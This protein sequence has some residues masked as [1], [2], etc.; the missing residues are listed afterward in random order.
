[1]WASPGKVVATTLGIVVSICANVP[2]TGAE[3]D[4]IGPPSPLSGPGV[5]S[6]KKS[7][8]KK[9]QRGWQEL[10][11]GDLTA[12]KKRA[13]RVARTV[14]GRLLQLQIDLAEGNT[15]VAEELRSFCSDQ[16]DYAAAWATLSLAAERSGAEHLALEAAR[17][18]EAQWPDS[19][20]SGRVTEL[21]QRWV[22]DRIAEATHLFEAGRSEEALVELEA[23]EALAPGH[24]DAVLLEAKIR[25]A[26]DDIRGAEDLLQGLP[27]DP[28]AA[29]LMGKIAESRSD[30][31]S[32]MDSF[33]ALPDDY[34]GREAALERAQVLWRLN[35]LPA[36]ARDSMAADPVT[37]GDL[38]VILISI[39]PRL[40]T[41]PGGEV[42]VMSDIVDHPGQREI[43]T[44]ARLGIMTVDRRGHLFQPDN[45]ANEATIRGAIRRCRLLLGLPEPVWCTESDV[46]GS[47]CTS[48]PSPASGGAIV[49]AVLDLAAGARP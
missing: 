4:G 47:G 5:P 21:E 40:E 1:M 49:N 16:P 30:W 6:I 15:D 24:R 39:Q 13:T 14:P 31:Q 42:P 25:F 18:T 26:D 10:V 35:L 27:D 28:D 48:I 20:W 36:Y 33:S 7:Q 22:V 37:R 32:A 38:A 44:I 45:R 8:L 11:E 9:V 17:Q 43:I 29:Y 19:P 46:I 2:H 3:P 41:L 23:V 12:A 34:P